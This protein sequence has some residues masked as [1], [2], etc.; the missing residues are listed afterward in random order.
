VRRRPA[1][2][3]RLFRR[4]AV[5]GNQHGEEQ[6][7]QQRHAVETVK[8]VAAQEQFVKQVKNRQAHC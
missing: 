6:N 5:E 1:N 4:R 2:G 8:G 7:A 3:C